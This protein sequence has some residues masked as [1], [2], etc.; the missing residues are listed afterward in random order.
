MAIGRRG[1]QIGELGLSADE[2]CFEGAAVAFCFAFCF[3]LG[4]GLVAFDEAFV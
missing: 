1:A 4:W 2:V 3:A